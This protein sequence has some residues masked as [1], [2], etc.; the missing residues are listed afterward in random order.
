[1]ETKIKLNYLTFCDVI[2]LIHLFIFFP[3]FF[4]DFI[5]NDS[6]NPILINCSNVFNSSIKIINYLLYYNRYIINLLLQ[7]HL[8]NLF[9]LTTYW[10]YPF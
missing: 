5:D 2:Q 10:C 3:F 7:Y 4:I 8:L 6:S 1:M 9:L